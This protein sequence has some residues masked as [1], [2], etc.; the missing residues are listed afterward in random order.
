MLSSAKDITYPSLQASALAE[1]L[2]VDFNGKTSS[3]LMTMQFIRFTSILLALYVVLSTAPVVLC[4]E[5]LQGGVNISKE[6]PA[7]P[8]ELRA[9]VIFN[10]ANLPPMGTNQDWRWIPS[11]AAGTWHRETQ[12]NFLPTGPQTI[13]SRSV[14]ETQEGDQMDSH[15][16]VWKHISLP[17]K[18][19]IEEDRYTE[20]QIVTHWEPILINETQ[21]VRR[22][23][24]MAIMVNRSNNK[25]A[26]V[27]QKE[28]FDTYHPEGQGAYLQDAWLTVYNERGRQLFSERGQAHLYQI[29]PFEPIAIDPKTGLDL[30]QDFKN[31]LLSHGLANLVPVDELAQPSNA[32]LTGSR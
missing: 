19:T 2:M 4:N 12:T 25:I 9:G 17:K 10:E 1:L 22:S 27:V 28:E 21:I 29:H 11:W 18:S 20:Y 23:R 14:N 7:V 16:G 5:P 3:I 15:G 6:L 13:L 31:Y 30:R 24:F 8:S 26:K 32:Q